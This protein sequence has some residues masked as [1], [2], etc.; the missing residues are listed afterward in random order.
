MSES[1]SKKRFLKKSKA[2]CGKI[3]DRPLTPASWSAPVDTV[4]NKEVSVCWLSHALAQPVLGPT[5]PVP[6][7]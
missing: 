4:N 2:G 5:I 1:M 6:P 3:E 7:E